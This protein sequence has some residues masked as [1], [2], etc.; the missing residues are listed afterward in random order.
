M[1]DNVSQSEI[2]RAVEELLKIDIVSPPQSQWER[3][4]IY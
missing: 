3:L 1:N 4:S 2:D